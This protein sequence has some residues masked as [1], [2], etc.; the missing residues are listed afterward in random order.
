MLILHKN[1]VLL[2]KKKFLIAAKNM[3]NLKNL[4]NLAKL[5]KIKILKLMK[6]R[7]QFL[8]MKI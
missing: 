7:F 8:K 1:K 4:H 6:L 5:L 3:N 2:K